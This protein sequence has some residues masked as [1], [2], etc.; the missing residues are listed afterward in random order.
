MSAD[1]QAFA[2]AFLATWR[3]ALWSAYARQ[4]LKGLD[5]GYMAHRTGRSAEDI[6]AGMNVPDG[7]DL[8][9]LSDLCF[10]MHCTPVFEM[11][12]GR[13]VIRVEIDEDEG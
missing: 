8:G 5:I 2:E 6:R 7:M 13:V 1:R 12:G 3:A 4:V 11:V 10:G 9:M